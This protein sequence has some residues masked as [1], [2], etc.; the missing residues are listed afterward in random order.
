MRDKNK[1]FIY[2]TEFFNK[3]IYLSEGIV[4]YGAGEYGKRL[5]DYLI[6]IGRKDKIKGIVVTDK[7]DAIDAYEGIAVSDAK[8]FFCSEKGS[9]YCVIVAVSLKYQSG[10]ILTLEKYGIKNY[11][12]LTRLAYRELKKRTDKRPRVTFEKID[13]LVAGFMKSGTTS[14]D[15]VLN[16]CE[17][18]YLPVGKE[19]HFF[20]WYNEVKDAKEKL[21]IKHFDDIRRGQKV[22]SVEPSFYANAK[23]ICQYFGNDVKIILMMRNPVNATFSLYKMLNRDGGDIFKELYQEYGTYHKD[24]FIR[25]FEDVVMDEKYQFNYDYWLKDFMKYFSNKQ[26]LVV[27]F[28]ELVKFPM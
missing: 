26:I 3:E 11:Y 15:H 28:E 6:S 19:T 9:N 12:C 22:G 7:K 2:R 23:E 10:V 4:I 25:Y 16:D 17:D 24:M 27:I 21:I 14:V 20:Y 13:F 8:V 18:I 5:I 1:Y